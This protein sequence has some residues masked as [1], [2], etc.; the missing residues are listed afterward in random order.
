MT[1]PDFFALDRSDPLAGLRERFRLPEGVVYFDGNSLGALPAHVPGRIAEVV[2]TE[3]G[4]DLIASWNH[5]H[6]IDLPQRVGDR[7]GRLIGAAPGQVLCCDSSSVNLFKALTTALG[8]NPGRRIILSLADNFPTD[9]Y[10]AQ[11][12]AGLLGEAR[13][14]L[15]TVSAGDLSA[16][17]SEEIAVLMLTQVNFRD[18]ELLDMRAITRAAH[19]HG[20]L[21]IWDLAHSAGAV[22]LALDEWQ[23][24]IA[25]GCGYKFLNGGPGAPAFVYLAS[26]HHSRVEQPLSGWLGHAEPFAFNPAYEAGEG[27]R[28]YQV[29]TPGIIGMSALDAALDLFDATSIEALREKSLTLSSLFIEGLEQ[30]PALAAC[31]L[32]TPREA[33]RRG[34][35]VSLSHPEGYAL[36]QA[37]IDSGVIV[38]F[39]APD[40]VRFGFAPLYNRYADVGV[41]LD[42]LER[43]LTTDRL[44]HF[45][46][47]PRAGVT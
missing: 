5:H 6:W 44:A 29:G 11:G 9:L 38:D 28:R 41:A 25:V 1:P 21:V 34:S 12:L 14:E 30:R 31:D 33:D 37:L 40:V 39:R 18:G 27:I 46:D 15:R 35:Q 7:I 26:R 20:V 2:A 13:C 3:W 45:R 16:Q 8:L 36:A 23:V 22:P 47:R 43:V 24:D 4:E 32:L 42:T 17:L 10:V 19:E